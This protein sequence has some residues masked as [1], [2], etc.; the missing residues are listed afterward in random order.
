MLVPVC[1]SGCVS[2]DA[3]PFSRYFL[4]Q[5]P[6]DEFFFLEKILNIPELVF[7]LF[8]RF[9]LYNVTHIYFIPFGSFRCGPRGF[10]S[11]QCGESQVPILVVGVQ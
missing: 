7:E 8:S 6:V 4:W 5:F 3:P 1:S 9:L 2:I 11:H 10:L